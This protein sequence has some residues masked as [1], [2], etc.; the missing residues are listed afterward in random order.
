MGWAILTIQQQVIYHARSAFSGGQLSEDGLGCPLD[1]FYRP[2][3]QTLAEISR[4]WRVPCFAPNPDDFHK[5][6]PENIKEA[7]RLNDWE[8]NVLMAGL[9]E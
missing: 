7:N 4:I 9:T 6:S 8:K 1:S 3:S 5:S 2:H